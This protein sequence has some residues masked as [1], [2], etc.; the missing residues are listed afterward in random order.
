MTKQIKG[1]VVYNA[2]GPG[3]WGIVDERGNQWRPVN[4]PENL[5]QKGKKVQVRIRE[6][7][8][9][10]SIFMWGSPVRIL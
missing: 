7:N 5:K 2:I 9:D 8:E 10:F 3:F 6:I 1:R 4:M